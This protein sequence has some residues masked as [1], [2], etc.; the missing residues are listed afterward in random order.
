MCKWM[1]HN[2]G[3]SPAIHPSRA[4]SELQILSVIRLNKMPELEAS[5]QASNS[6]TVVTSVYLIYL[7]SLYVCFVC[8]IKCP[9]FHLMQH[10]PHQ[11]NALLHSFPFSLVL[12]FWPL[13][14]HTHTSIDT[15]VRKAWAVGILLS[16]VQT[17]F[18]TWHSLA[19]PCRADNWSIGGNLRQRTWMGGW[20]LLD[21]LTQRR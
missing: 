7:A 11:H 15:L 5:W 18:G 14:M 16:H 3:S 12:L 6:W 10:W 17:L 9:L 8:R 1:Q 4:V 20:A 19:E 13:H 21:G 2:K